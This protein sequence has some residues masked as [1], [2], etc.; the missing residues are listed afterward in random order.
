LILSKWSKRNYKKQED[1]IKF[2]NHS[3]IHYKDN[4]IIFNKNIFYNY[5]LN[6]NELSTIRPLLFT[7]EAEKNTILTIINNCLYVIGKIKH[8]DD[9]FIFKTNID[10]FY[11]KLN[12]IKD[13]SYEVLLNNKDYSD[14]IFVL[15]AGD[16]NREIHV[17][18]KVMV[19]NRI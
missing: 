14:I 17:N 13:K 3:T 2:N 15:N 8:Y 4:I 7:P 5:D 6:S 10:N 19:I 18:K 9:C 11:T 12:I 1:E 16:R